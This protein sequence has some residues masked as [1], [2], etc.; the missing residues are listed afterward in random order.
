MSNGG[1][2]EIARSLK[3]A[4]ARIDCLQSEEKM[5]YSTLRD[6]EMQ[7]RRMRYRYFPRKFFSDVAWDI[8]LDLDKFEEA[9]VQC[10]VTDIGVEAQI[11]LATILR[12]LTK[13]EKD[14]FISRRVDKRDQRR[15]LV[16]LTT[17]GRSALDSTY[18]SVTNNQS[19]D[20]LSSRSSFL[21]G[22]STTIPAVKVDLS[23]APL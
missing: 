9:G 1:I 16:A 15:S 11:S 6:L 3:D 23:I 20:S 4:L 21:L 14:G 17:L 10:A 5:K 22:D 7:L 12:Y 13:L 8:L 18:G 19:D 2:F